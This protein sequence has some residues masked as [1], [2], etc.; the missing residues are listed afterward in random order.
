MPVIG[1]VVFSAL[2]VIAQQ[3]IEHLGRAFHV[4]G[5]DLDEAAGPMLRTR[6]RFAAK[7]SVQQ[8]SIP[9]KSGRFGSGRIL[10]QNIGWE[11]I[12]RSKCID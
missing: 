5:Q 1:N 8:E 12:Y 2:K 10:W 7:F 9:G 4:L 3:Q 11:I 6:K